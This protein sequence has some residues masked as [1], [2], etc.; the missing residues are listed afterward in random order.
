MPYIYMP[1]LTPQ[2]HPNVSIYGSPRRVVPGVCVAVQFQGSP[3]QVLSSLLFG[4]PPTHNNVFTERPRSRALLYRTARSERGVARGLRRGERG[5]HEDPSGPG[6]E[7][8]E[9]AALPRVR[10]LERN[11]S[12]LARCSAVLEG[13]LN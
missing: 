11:D 1:T 5:L 7:E 3:S 2:N 4:P 12:G 10:C 9:E 8:A 6:E 13:G